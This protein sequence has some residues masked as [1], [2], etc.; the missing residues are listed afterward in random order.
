MVPDIW[1]YRDLRVIQLAES[2]PGWWLGRDDGVGGV[3]QG[4]K[5]SQQQACWG[6]G[7]PKLKKERGKRPSLSS[8]IC[9]SQNC[10]S[11]EHS[12]QKERWAKDQPELDVQEQRVERVTKCSF[13]K[14]NKK[15]NNEGMQK[16]I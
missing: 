6:K 9:Y 8:R 1:E 7:H 12:E 11:V 4:Q 16:S 3:L 15:Q 5:V 14:K 2:R 13:W 10:W